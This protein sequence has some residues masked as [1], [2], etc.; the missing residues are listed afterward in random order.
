[1]ISKIGDYF[2][3]AMEIVVALIIST[4]IPRILRSILNRF[5]LK[6]EIDSN[7]ETTAQG[8]WQKE[9]YARDQE[10]LESTG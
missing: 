8:E 9:Q 5:G 1:M 3:F 7:V 2:L 10:A 4:K 6:A